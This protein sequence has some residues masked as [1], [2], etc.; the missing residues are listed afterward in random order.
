MSKFLKFSL[1]EA[2]NGNDGNDYG[3]IGADFSNSTIP[4]DIRLSFYGFAQYTKF[5]RPGYQ[6]ISSNDDDTL[7]AQDANNKTLVLVCTN[8]NNAPD[9]WSINVSK[10]NISLFNVYR[11]SNDNETLKLLPNTWS[12][13]D[14][15]LIYESPAN[16]ITTFV[17]N[18]TQ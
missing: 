10:F 12:I 15:I 17:F 14:G 1:K 11:T 9:A 18:V 2:P 5:I 7:A 6:I 3:L 13:T 8:K 4:L 16:S